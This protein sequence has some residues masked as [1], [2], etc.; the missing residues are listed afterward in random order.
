MSKGKK[1]KR[2]Y[3]VDAAKGMPSAETTKLPPA[4]HPMIESIVVRDVATYA[5]EGVNF[6]NLQLITYPGCS[7]SENR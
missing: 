4:P 5:H 6:D 7:P 1:Q 3:Q 2:K